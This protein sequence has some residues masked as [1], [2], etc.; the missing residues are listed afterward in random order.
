MAIEVHS[1]TWRAISAHLTERIEALTAS[2]LS[3]QPEDSTR[4]TRA[5]ISE[6]MTLLRLPETMKADQI[7]YPSPL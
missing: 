4:K 6:C 1:P 7:H 2:L 3:D 5:Q